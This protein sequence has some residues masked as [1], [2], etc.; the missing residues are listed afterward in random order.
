[1]PR[2]SIIIVNWNGLE[3]LETCLESLKARTFRTLE[4]AMVNKGATE[5]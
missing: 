5:G 1:M 3:H 2:V 4:M